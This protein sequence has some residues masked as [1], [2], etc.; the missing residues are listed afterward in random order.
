LTQHLDKARLISLTL[1]NAEFH[2]VIYH[3]RYHMP[4]GKT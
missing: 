1:K 2:H 4:Y 3:M